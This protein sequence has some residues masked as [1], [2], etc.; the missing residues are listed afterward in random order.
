MSGFS[1]I[2]GLVGET[3]SQ[4][5]IN[6]SSSTGDVTGTAGG[7]SLGG[8]LG[9][10]LRRITIVE[11]YAAGDVTGDSRTRFTGGLVGRVVTGN[12][13]D[14][15]TTISG[16]YATGAVTGGDATGGLVGSF[17]WDGTSSYTCPPPSSC[18]ITSSFATGAVEGDNY[19]GGLVGISFNV[20]LDNTFATGAVSNS[21]RYVGGL[22]G[23]ANAGTAVRRS[24]VANSVGGNS[25]VGALVG[26]S[27]NTTYA[28]SFFA[29][30]LG[31]AN[32]LG[33]N[34]NNAADINPAGTTGAP[35]ADLQTPTAAGQTVNAEDLYTNWGSEWNFGSGAQLPGLVIDGVVYRDGNADGALD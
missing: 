9:V 33:T 5:S 28:D 22:I 10:A 13:P 19:V 11:S 25:D 20:E 15:F 3:D 8:L 1:R 2:G 14:Q 6:N 31:Q 30:D 7:D 16:S 23:D 17:N 21:I 35:L 24:F 29:D 4:V 18:M 26:F 32:A 12:A 27:A 34:F